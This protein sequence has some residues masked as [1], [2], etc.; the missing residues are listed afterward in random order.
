VLIIGWQQAKL[1]ANYAARN[2]ILDSRLALFA[3]K[4]NIRL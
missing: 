4:M 3:I 2:F 1:R